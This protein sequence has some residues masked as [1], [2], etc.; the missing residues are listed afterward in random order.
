MS[1]PESDYRFHGRR[2]GRKLRPGMA[3]L[4]GERLPDYEIDLAGDGPLEPRSWFRH[5]PREVWLEIGFGGGEHLAAQAAANPDVG[6]VGFEP[7]LN[8]VSTLLRAVE[9]Q[10]LANVR[11]HADDVRPVLPRLP[12]GCLDRVFVLFPD[13]WPKTRHHDR[14]IVQHE[15]VSAF[16]R[17]L[18]PGGEA[19]FASDDMD[20]VRW[21]LDRFLA[22]GG[23]RWTADRAAD[24]RARPDDWPATRYEAKAIRQGRAPAF[25]RFQKIGRLDPEAA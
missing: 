21:A 5:Q 16:H 25:L 2:R 8:G 24:W 15:T 6:I 20:Y 4:L 17:L 12:D 23:F 11:V 19:R 10:G 14:R 22:H 7:F 13:P 18:R 3:R 9:A 1:E